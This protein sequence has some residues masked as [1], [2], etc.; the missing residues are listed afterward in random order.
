MG[1]RH[2]VVTLFSAIFFGLLVPGCWD[3]G[4]NVPNQTPPAVST[5][6]PDSGGVGDSIRLFGTGFGTTRAASVV[7]F[8]SI[9]AQTYSVWSDTLIVTTVPQNSTTAAITVIVGTSVSNPVNFKVLGT[10]PSLR[11]FSRDILPRLTQYGCIGCHGGNG[12]LY[13]DTRQR[14]LQGGSH[15]PAVVP[16]DAEGSLLIKKM[17]TNP[18]FGSRMPQGGPYLADSSTEVFKDWINQGAIDN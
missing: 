2:T 6:R 14:L 1:K 7:R 16:G 9:D 17:S 5:I 11:S 12:G 10:V 4:S 15:G 13:L 3:L 18:P 8:G